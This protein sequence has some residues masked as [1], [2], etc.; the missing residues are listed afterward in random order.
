[1]TSGVHN[2]A[3]A[4]V[5][6]EVYDSTCAVQT[7]DILQEQMECYRHHRTM[8]TCKFACGHDHALLCEDYMLSSWALCLDSLVATVVV[9]TRNDCCFT[10][11]V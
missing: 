1:M 5:I 4:V 2:V 7:H 6:V 3:A 11:C 10:H 9:D 8:R